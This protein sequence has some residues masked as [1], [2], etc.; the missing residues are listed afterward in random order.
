MIIDTFSRS[1]DPFHHPTAV[2]CVSRPNSYSP[3]R[4]T[5]KHVHNII[6][7]TFIIAPHTHTLTHFLQP[8]SLI[9]P[10]FIHYSFFSFYLSLQYMY[11]LS[12]SVHLFLSPSLSSLSL[13]L[14]LSLSLSLSFRLYIFLY[15]FLSHFL[16]PHFPSSLSVSSTFLSFLLPLFS[17]S[18][19]FSLSLS[20]SP[21]STFPQAI[22]LSLS[23]FIS[24]YFFH[25]LSL[26]SSFYLPLFLSLSCPVGWGC[27]IHR[28]LLCR[29]V[30]PPPTLMSVLDMIL[31][32]FTF[33]WCWSFGECRAPLHCHCSQVHSGS[34][35]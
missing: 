27:R 14:S 29:R 31:N 18:L 4:W 24:L 16:S 21:L 9:P 26:S 20:L 5:L 19:Y 11:L 34:E 2:P 15:T 3:M 28:L 17:I 33:Q 35:W 8:L 7:H 10:F 22:F 1:R 6:E 13:F 32:N 12:F 25:H 30:R 23:F